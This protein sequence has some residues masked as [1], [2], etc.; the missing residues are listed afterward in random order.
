MSMALPKKNRLRLK[1]D[2]QDI[3]KNNLILNTP[4]FGVSYMKADSNQPL[5]G[6]IISKKISA[7]AVERNKLKRKLS[8]AI[9]PLLPQINNNYK[10]I[11][12][13]KRELKKASFA[14]ISRQAENALKNIG[15]L[16]KK[17]PD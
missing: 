8:E 1:K 2:F 11:F 12:L 14:D 10:I 6:F 17:Q 9:R 16:G 15:A 7:K 5:I 3:K 4:L 13:G